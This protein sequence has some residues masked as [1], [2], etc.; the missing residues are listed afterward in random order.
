MTHPLVSRLTLAEK[1]A[2]V[3][4]ATFWTTTAIERL[5]IE[6]LTLSDGPHGVRFQPA[7]TDHLG[8]NASVP[9]TAFP[10]ASSLG[11]SWDRELATR[12]GEALGREARA[13]G[14]DIL[15]G[16]GV[17]IKRSPLCGRNF[18]Y[19][20]EDPF[21]SGALGAAWTDGV[22]S[23]GV[24]VSVKHFAANNQESDRMRISADVDERT[25]R[26]I[27]LPAFETV[28]TRSR[29]ATVMSSYNRINGVHASQNTRLLTDLLR[30]EWGFEGFVVSDWGGVVDPVAA[31]AAGNDLEMPSTGDRGPTAI[32]AAVDG[33][34]LD[35]ALLDA[36]VSRI[37][38]V[39]DALRARRETQTALD[40]DAHHQLAR[41][42]AAAGAVLLAN[43]TGLL[44]LDAAGTG[45]I[46]VIGEFARTPRYQGAGSSHINPTRLDD[47]L[48]AI[49]ARTQRE[50]AFE[51]G[52]TLEKTTSEQTEELAS[53]AVAAAEKADVVVLFLGL[54]DSAESE[55]F[56]RT[57]L[58]LPADQLALLERIRGVNAS[59]VVVLSNGSVVSLE[60]IAGSVPAVLEMWL[61]GQ[62]S[63]SAACDVLFGDSEPGGRLAETIPH[64]LTDT[65]AIG[66]WPGANGHVLYGERI[67][68]GYRWY[69]LTD[70]DVAFPFGH[71]LGYTSYSYTD[72]AVHIADASV[73]AAEVEITVT[74]TGARTG[75]EVVQLYVGDPDASVDRPGRELRAFEKIQLAPGESQRV[76][77]ALGERAFAFWSEEGWLVE[78]GAF[79][80]E[81]GAS[82]RDLRA[83]EQIVL[84]VPVPVREL[85]LS[86]SLKEW[87]THPTGSA[88]FAELL[89][90]LGPGAALLD[91]PETLR[92]AESMPLPTVVSIAGTADG[93]DIVQ[94]L[95]TSLETTPTR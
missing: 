79:T 36:A 93:A 29:P 3:S 54:P 30:E 61:G 40:L 76:R 39:N 24:G 48:T 41:R 32:A 9:A 58:R 49:R 46:A 10:T 59:T 7:G 16:P 90:T 81:V 18:E 60:G 4:G 89:G 67:Y 77:F 75:S 70:R 31:V 19:L 33:G 74:N 94:Q 11:S 95:L 25:L 78:P 71:G 65:P 23:R 52:F 51:A 42:A 87:M 14:V 45:S 72:L 2:L 20:S 12:V 37:L 62:A 86:S 64:R 80:I 35:E 63:G 38:T 88:A 26:E 50:V 47:A 22:Q 73:A 34:E 27:Y 91:D 66:N 21:L 92:I 6:A 13:L 28:V 55:G 8:L 57:H 1:A 82:S 68:V 17:N 85:T 15:L 84:E 53:A 44:P 43:D 83:R 69:D 5:G 56:D